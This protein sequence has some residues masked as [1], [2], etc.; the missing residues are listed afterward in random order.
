VRKKS[1]HLARTR[2][3]SA[4]AEMAFPVGAGPMGGYRG[5][6]R[7][8]AVGATVGDNSGHALMTHSVIVHSKN[9]LRIS[10]DQGPR[11]QLWDFCKFG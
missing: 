7:E 2:Q 5:Q 1:L 6:P 8:V 3:G 4:G 10:L 11:T 9:I